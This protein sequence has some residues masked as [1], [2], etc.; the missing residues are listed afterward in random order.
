MIRCAICNSV[1]ADPAR[2][3][4]A[5]AFFKG[6]TYAHTACLEKLMTDPTPRAFPP[7]DDAGNQ[8][9]AWCGEPV[10]SSGKHFNHDN[11]R[12]T[13][14]RTKPL[15]GE[16]APM[17]APGIDTQAYWDAI[18][19]VDPDVRRQ[20]LEGDW[21]VETADRRAFLDALAARLEMGA[22][23]Y[24]NASFEKPLPVTAAE[25][26]AEALDIAGWGYVMWVQIRRRCER[27]QRAV[28]EAP[29]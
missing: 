1:I 7:F 11:S 23:E 21:R 13:C 24:D 8:I 28:D 26:E 22:R 2:R 15:P 6:A 18:Q 25:L 10:R 17:V 5:A 19:N 29:E 14:V 16:T 12:P 27:L 20:L 9:C 4:L 3:R